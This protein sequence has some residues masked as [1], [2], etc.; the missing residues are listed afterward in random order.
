[1]GNIIDKE[2]FKLATESDENFEMIFDINQRYDE[3]VEKLEEEF[4]EEFKKISKEK[5][6]YIKINEDESYDG[7][8]LKFRLNSLKYFCFYFQWN[9][10]N[11][12]LFG[13]I[14]DDKKRL[15]IRTQINPVNEQLRKV[16]KDYEQGE[17]IDFFQKILY[18]FSKIS[19]LK[20]LLQH[21]RK[22]FISEIIAKINILIK[23]TET[24]LITLEKEYLK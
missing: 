11:E 13:L 20:K 2:I 10:N 21:N 17:V 18:D 3:I 8:F 14:V 9:T 24:E 16:L 7:W 4:W 23:H 5:F 22:E 6:D 19:D 1:M 12:M 15:K